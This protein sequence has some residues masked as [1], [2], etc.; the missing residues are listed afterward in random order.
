MAC[1]RM[2]P[3][4]EL[5]NDELVRDNTN[6]LWNCAERLVMDLA[7]HQRGRHAEFDKVNREVT[8]QATEVKKLQPK[9]KCNI[10]KGFH[11]EKKEQDHHAQ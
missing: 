11:K 3:F 8:I 9:E 4:S 5:E 2:K 7:L 1:M 10:C 6:S